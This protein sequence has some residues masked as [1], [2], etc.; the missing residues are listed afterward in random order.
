[1]ANMFDDF[2][3]EALDTA[4]GVIGEAIQFNT[5]TITAAIS[6]VNITEELMDGGLLEKRGLKVVLALSESA[7]PAVGNKILYKGKGYRVIDVSE[8]SIS[9][10]LTCDTDAK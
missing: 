5:K 1:M 8:D 3:K 4:L 7:V 10:T 9:Y 6:D 2:G